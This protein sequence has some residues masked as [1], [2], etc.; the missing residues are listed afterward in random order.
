LAGDLNAKHQFWNNSVSNPS[1]KEILELFDK[2]EFE[3]SAPQCPPHY[4]L[5]GNGDI[6]DIAVHQ[7]IRLSDATVSDILDS[8][9]LPIIFYLL[10]PVKVRN[11]QKPIEKITGNSFKKLPLN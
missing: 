7:N 4:F 3:I 9:H 8:D 5:T 6:L 10:E 1:G 11:L 2:N